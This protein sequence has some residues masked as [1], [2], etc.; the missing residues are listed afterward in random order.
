MLCCVV[1]CCVVLCCV[2]L[3][4]VVLCCNVSVRVVVILTAGGVFYLFHSEGR[5]A[6]HVVRTEEVRSLLQSHLVVP[7]L[8]LLLL[9]FHK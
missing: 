5:T 8:L 6:L 2:V 9:Y 4:C 1:L 7:A 3:C